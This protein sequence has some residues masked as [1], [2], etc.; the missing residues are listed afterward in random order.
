LPV[1][2]TEAPHLLMSSGSDTV[3]GTVA[4]TVAPALACGECL[5]TQ[6]E[7]AQSEFYKYYVLPLI[8]FTVVLLPVTYAV[9]LYFSLKTHSDRIYLQQALVRPDAAPGKGEGGT[10]TRACPC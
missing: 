5:Y 10:L 2:A 8:Y 9:G 1:N 6:A 3:V 4:A 7:P